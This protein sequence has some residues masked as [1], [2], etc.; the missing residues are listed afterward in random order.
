MGNNYQNRPQG[1]ISVSAFDGDNVVDGKKLIPVAF[2]HK[3]LLVD[4]LIFF[5][6]AMTTLNADITYR[7]RKSTN[8]VMADVTGETTLESDDYEALKVY[9]VV[10]PAST[11]KLAKGE[12]LYLE[13][14]GIPMGFDVVVPDMFVSVDIEVK[15][16]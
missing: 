16:S 1:I 15:G 4:E 6:G 8:G 7:L 2:G 14:G 3:S 9:S 13:L 10:P 5:F 11:K 12:I